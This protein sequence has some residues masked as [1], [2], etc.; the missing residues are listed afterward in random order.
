MTN[1]RSSLANFTT[2]CDNFLICTHGKIDYKAKVQGIMVSTFTTISTEAYTIAYIENSYDN[3]LAEAK[4]STTDPM[5]RKANSVKYA[6]KKWTVDSYAA[7]IYGGWHRDGLIYYM[8]KSSDI[9]AERRTGEH[10]QLEEDYMKGAAKMYS[11]KVRA[12][13]AV[14]EETDLV[15]EV[16]S[17]EERDEDKEGECD[18][19]DQWTR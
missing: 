14:V 4:D 6:K 1:P 11:R 18:N 5:E 7:K 10:R 15:L 2:F 8:D 16:Y 3:W 9:R 19:N 12:P 17:E 13:K